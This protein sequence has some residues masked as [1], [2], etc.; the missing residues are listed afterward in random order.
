M[1]YSESAEDLAAMQESACDIVCSQWA[2]FIPSLKRVYFITGQDYH[3]RIV[4]TE[5]AHGFQFRVLQDT[6]FS[7]YATK[8]CM[9]HEGEVQ[10]KVFADGLPW[11]LKDDY[12]LASR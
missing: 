7:W 4:G 11:I 12:I 8:V 5:Y 2:P 9:W 6:K 3:I 10:D 1:L